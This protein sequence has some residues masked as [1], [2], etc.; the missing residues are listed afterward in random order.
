MWTSLHKRRFRRY[1]LKD[2]GNISRQY[3]IYCHLLTSIDIYCHLLS[4]IVI[5]WHLLTSIVIY[6]HLLT[7]I[8]IYWHLLTSIDIYR[9][10]LTSIVIYW[11]LLTSID[12]YWHL[13]T[14]HFCKISHRL[15]WFQATTG[16]WLPMHWWRPLKTWTSLSPGLVEEQEIPVKYCYIAVVNPHSTNLG[17]GYIWTMFGLDVHLFLGDFGGIWR[18]PKLGVSKSWMVFVRE[19][20]I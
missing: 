15:F 14:S 18:F 10:L 5:Y 8:V 2:D 20:S 7:S 16:R 13:L 1:F 19:N 12:I 3:D 17:A 9:H 11:H 6:W 4:S